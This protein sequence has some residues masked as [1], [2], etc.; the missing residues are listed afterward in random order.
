MP[1]MPGGQHGGQVTSVSRPRIASSVSLAV[2]CS[3][4]PARRAA[5]SAPIANEESLPP[6]CPCRSRQRRPTTSRPR[7]SRNRKVPADVITGS[8]P[9][10]CRH[11]QREQAGAAASRAGSRRPVA[12]PC[13][14]ARNGCGRRTR[15][16]APAPIRPASRVPRDHTPASRAREEPHDSITNHQRPQGARSDAVGHKPPQLRERLRD[17]LRPDTDR[18]AKAFGKTVSVSRQAQSE[19]PLD[20]QHIRGD[21]TASLL[22]GDLHNPLRREMRQRLPRTSTASGS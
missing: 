20:V 16:P 12:C 17:Q 11:P 3:P 9:A 13:A 1:G 5:R 18:R 7:C 15:T 8:T 4:A 14:G 22:L 10:G 6:S 21:R 2:S 19:Q